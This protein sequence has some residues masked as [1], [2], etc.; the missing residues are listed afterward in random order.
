MKFLVTL[1]SAGRI[2]WNLREKK[3]TKEKIQEI[4]SAYRVV[5]HGI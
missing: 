5:Q 3:Y 1:S 2:P 4:Q